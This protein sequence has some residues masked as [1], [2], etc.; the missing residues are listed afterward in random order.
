MSLKVFVICASFKRK[1]DFASV[2][3]VEGLTLLGGCEFGVLIVVSSD[4]SVI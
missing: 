3:R 1:D 2:Y 4:F